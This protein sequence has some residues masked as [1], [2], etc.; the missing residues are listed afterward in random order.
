MGAK[1]TV[2]TQLAPV[3]SVVQLLV[4]AKRALLE[5]TPVTVSVP[6]PTLVSVT[7]TPGVTVPTEA[8]PN[9]TEAGLAE[10]VAP[11]LKLAVT[12][13]A[14]ASVTWQVPVPLQPPPDQP[15]KVEPAAA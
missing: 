4:C 5:A 10:P 9:A 1:V 14:A 15:A 13:V 11:A 8:P 7:A 3:P 6:V 2:A 12:V